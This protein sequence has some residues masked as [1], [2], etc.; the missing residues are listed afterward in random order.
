MNKR[1]GK[2]MHAE[3]AGAGFAGSD[4]RGRVGAA[5]LERDGCT[6]RARNCARSAPVFISGTMGLRVLEGIDALEDVLNGSHTPPIYE[7]WR[8]NNSVSRETFNGLPWRI[9]TRQHLH[10]ALANKARAGRRRNPH[11]FRSGE[12]A[13]RPA[14]SS[15]RRRESARP[16]L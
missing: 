12:G 2:T 1:S 4:G 13:T 8:H 15:S 16:I 10:D 7:T 3:I 9:M 11:Q 5:R 14:R 6:K